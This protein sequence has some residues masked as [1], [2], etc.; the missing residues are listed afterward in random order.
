MSASSLASFTRRASAPAETPG[1]GRPPS[2]LGQHRRDVRVGG[3]DRCDVVPP[4]DEHVGVT[5]SR[6]SRARPT[7]CRV[8]PT[9]PQAT[10]TVR[11]GNA[12]DS[13][14]AI[15]GYDRADLGAPEELS[16]SWLPRGAGEAVG[17]AADFA[18][19]D[20]VRA[21]GGRAGR[22]GAD[23]TLQ[24]R[25]DDAP[26]RALPIGAIDDHQ[27]RLALD[28]AHNAVSRPFWTACWVR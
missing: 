20:R 10:F 15:I 13:D 16:A 27:R 18:L 19:G 28:R 2:A 14:A 6:A 21:G 24:R 4:R 23:T 22:H 17:S 7:T 3:L 5:C 25:R 26:L 12:G 1:A 9:P 8:R 11:V